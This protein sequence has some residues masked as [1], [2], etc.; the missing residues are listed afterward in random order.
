MPLLASAVALAAAAALAACG[1]SPHPRSGSAGS[2]TP[3][4]S[5]SGLVAQA[6][7]HS[8]CM[9]SHGVP[10]FPDPQ[11]DNGGH[12]ISIHVSAGLMSAPAFRSARQTCARYLPNGGAGLLQTGNDRAHAEA[13]LAFARCIRSHGFSNFPDPTAQ[14]RLDPSMI[15]AAGINL[16]QPAVL[17][18]GLACIGVTHGDI[19]RTDV[20]QAVNGS[21]GQGTQ[22]SASQSD[23]GSA[24]GG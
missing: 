5:S 16:H 4:H 15:T 6:Y 19:T 24:A 9:R 22:S 3:G 8:A 13:M 12:Q 17:H 21:G 18:A 2:N 14:G 1:G 7:K 20:E 23:Q 10:N 11:V